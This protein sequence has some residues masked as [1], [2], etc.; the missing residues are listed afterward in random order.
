VGKDQPFTHTGPSGDN[1][2][3][4]P[5]T[6]DKGGLLGIMGDGGPRRLWAERRHQSTVPRGGRI[7]RRWL[8]GVAPLLSQT[9]AGLH[10]SQFRPAW[11][12]II[13]PNQRL[14]L[15]PPSQNRHFPPRIRE[16]GLARSSSRPEDFGSDFRPP[17][18]SGRLVLRVSNWTWFSRPSN[19]HHL[20]ERS[21]APSYL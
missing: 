12:F 14:G 4:S 20:Q 18:G 19:S 13:L 5:V 1:S 8:G 2:A 17:S 15:M 7:I 9:F 11:R 6:S 21:K 3:T 10:Y 16:V